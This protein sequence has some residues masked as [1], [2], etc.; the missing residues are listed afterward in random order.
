MGNERLIDADTPHGEAM[1]FRQM[2]GTEALSIPFEYD[3]TFH[4]LVSGLSAKEMLGFVAA[5]NPR[6]SLLFADDAAAA[7][8][9]LS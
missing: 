6:F 3:V 1:W 5:T 2:T 4:S 9:E 7:L 8:K